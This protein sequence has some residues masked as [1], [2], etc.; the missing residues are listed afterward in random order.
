MQMKNRP[1]HLVCWRLLTSVLG[2]SS[3]AHLSCDRFRF[4]RSNHM[5]GFGLLEEPASNIKVPFPKLTL[6]TL[7]LRDDST[8][9]C[10]PLSFATSLVVKI[11]WGTNAKRLSNCPR[12]SNGS[13]P[14]KL[15][16]VSA[17][18]VKSLCVGAQMAPESKDGAPFIFSFV[19][20][21]AVFF[22]SWNN[23]TRECLHTSPQS[24]SSS[25]IMQA[26]VRMQQH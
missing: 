24:P 17:R 1:S 9:H 19:W 15:W 10:T 26:N 16:N 3:G 14:Q 8:H 18:N 23:D 22:P 25:P 21:S 4:P 11:N 5:H 7:L 13:A 12:L 6:T 2:E 20:L